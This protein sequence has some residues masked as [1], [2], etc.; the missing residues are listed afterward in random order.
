MLYNL[1]V[2][3]LDPKGQAIKQEDKDLTASE[4][5]YELLLLNDPRAELSGGA[6]LRNAKLAKRI[7]DCSEKVELDVNELKIIRDLIDKYASPGAVFGFECVIENGKEVQV[8]DFKESKKTAE[9]VCV[10]KPVSHNWIV[11][12][13]AYKL[14]LTNGGFQYAEP[15]DIIIL[16]KDHAWPVKKAYF[17]EHYDIVDPVTVPE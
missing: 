4:L 12:D 10:K 9:L 2:P 13:K 14:P 15:G 3:L 1:A 16:G 17:D 8:F 5:C 11:A 6:K 7:V